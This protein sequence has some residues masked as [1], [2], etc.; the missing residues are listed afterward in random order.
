M[1]G[2]QLNGSARP[3]VGD[4][5]ATFD[6]ARIDDSRLGGLVSIFCGVSREMIIFRPHVMSLFRP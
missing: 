6:M 3:T 4:G 2:M 5:N 1:G